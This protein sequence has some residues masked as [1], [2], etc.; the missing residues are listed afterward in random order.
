MSKSFE[1]IECDYKIDTNCILDWTNQLINYVDGG[2]NIR[3][4][5]STTFI[6]FTRSSS[7]RSPTNYSSLRMWSKFFAS[8][9]HPHRKQLHWNRMSYQIEIDYSLSNKHLTQKI[10]APFLFW[11]RISMHSAFLFLSH[12][13][14][15][16]LFSSL[17][18]C[19]WIQVQIPFAFASINK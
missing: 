15:A 11:S 3:R 7:P 9:C 5:H 12:I 4:C 13:D 17:F 8:H 6:Q 2:N 14:V 16:Q 10:N 18:C 19:C 1:G